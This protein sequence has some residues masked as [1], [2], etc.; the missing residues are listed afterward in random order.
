MNPRKW[1]EFT[2]NSST[3]CI[4]NSRDQ[5]KDTD[6][7]I[8]PVSVT[9]LKCQWFNPLKVYLMSDIFFKEDSPVVCN[10]TR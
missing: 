1:S 10:H 3:Q 4:L 6:T 8:T 2:K 7:R 5:E 9:A